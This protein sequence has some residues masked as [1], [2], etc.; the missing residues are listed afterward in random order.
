MRGGRSPDHWSLPGTEL[1]RACV[2]AAGSAAATR[3]AGAT[4]A[5]STASTTAASESARAA[6]AARGYQHH[7]RCQHRRQ[8]LA[9]P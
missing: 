4:A 3:T 1:W 2:R 9:H 7:R 6:R 5:A 8:N